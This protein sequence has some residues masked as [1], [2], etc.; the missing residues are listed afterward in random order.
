VKRDVNAE[1]A[2]RKELGYAGQRRRKR[3][4]AAARVEELAA[5]A[6]QLVLDLRGEGGSQEDADLTAYG[7][8]YWLRKQLGYVV[9]T[10]GP[11]G[12]PDSWVTRVV[13]REYGSEA[14]W[15]TPV[16]REG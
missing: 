12:P 13:E 2:E 9:N 1:I 16:N 7:R 3:M 5:I 8:V 11:P 15:T 4:D 6:K 10:L 14:G